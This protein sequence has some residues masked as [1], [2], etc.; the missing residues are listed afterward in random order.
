MKQIKLEI[1]SSFIMMRL[2][3][4]NDFESFVEW[5]LYD[6]ISREFTS[7]RILATSIPHKFNI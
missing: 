4:S 1:S 6:Y 2:T 5:K 3:A 7:M